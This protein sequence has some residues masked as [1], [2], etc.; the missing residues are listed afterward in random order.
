MAINFTQFDLKNPTNSDFLVG[1][2]SDGSAEYRTTVN[3]LLSSYIKSDT[4]T[5]PTASAVNNIVMISFAN[6]TT[7][8]KQSR[9]GHRVRQL[10]KFFPRGTGKWGR[11]G[12]MRAARGG[13][14]G[15]WAHDE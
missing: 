11:S 14:R 4:T 2:K 12:S 1:Y 5:I 8:G 13:A 10:S 9:I 6:F 15:A 7:C 3:G